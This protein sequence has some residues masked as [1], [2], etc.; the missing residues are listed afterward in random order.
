MGYIDSKLASFWINSKD[1]AEDL[2][3]AGLPRRGK[4]ASPGMP[5]C[6]QEDG[7]VNIAPVV[8]IRDISTTIDRIAAAAKLSAAIAAMPPQSAP[9]K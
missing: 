6:M 7:A 3:M 9:S 8:K 5:R 4:V 2:G 1:E